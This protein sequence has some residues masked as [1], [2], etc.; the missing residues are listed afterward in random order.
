MYM[1]WKKLLAVRG[2]SSNDR[3]KIREKNRAP[4]SDFSAHLNG[5]GDMKDQLNTKNILFCWTS[6][7]E[8][9]RTL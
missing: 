5:A 4:I 3:K 7:E 2:D 1:L 8:S 6:C 9:E